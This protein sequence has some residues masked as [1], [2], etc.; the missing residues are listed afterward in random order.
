ME[1]EH[2]LEEYLSPGDKAHQELKKKK[3]QNINIKL[4][5]KMQANLTLIMLL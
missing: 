2:G 1:Q 4:M 5:N 3:K